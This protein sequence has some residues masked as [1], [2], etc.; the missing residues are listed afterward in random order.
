[1]TEPNYILKNLKYNTKYYWQVSVS[2][3]INPKVLSCNTLPSTFPNARFL[4][5]KINDN[6]DLSGND[7][8]EQLQITTSATNSWR[9]RKNTQSQKLLLLDQVDRKT[10]YTP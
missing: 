8:G 2:D 1:L 4:S 9:P 5:K 10:I 3:G 6:S 7:A